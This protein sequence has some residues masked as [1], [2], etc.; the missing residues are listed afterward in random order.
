VQLLICAVES[1][2]R[3]MHNSTSS[4]RLDSEL[5]DGRLP[6][7]TAAVCQANGFDM[8]CLKTLIIRSDQ[9]VIY[10]QE[11]ETCMN[12]SSGGGGG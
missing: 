3:P 4:S 9:A 5:C 7:D 1:S 10:R 11:V 12:V 6:K 8:P 2:L